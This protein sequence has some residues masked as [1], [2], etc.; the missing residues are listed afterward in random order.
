M[1]SRTTKDIP[2]RDRKLQMRLRL[3]GAGILM[4]GMAAAAFVYRSA[5]P[6]YDS[7]YVRMLN[8]TKK[9]EYEMEVVGGKANVFAADVRDW[10]GS[11]WHGKR[12]AH[13]LAFLSVGGSFACFFVAHR[14]NY[15]PPLETPSKPREL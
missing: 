12:L 6:D 4:A 3:A 9:N 13:T 2:E 7:A 5:V 1:I 14:L 8:N 15:S 10:F 11:L